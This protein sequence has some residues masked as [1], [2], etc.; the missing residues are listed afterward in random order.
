MPAPLDAGEREFRC[1][2][3]LIAA[4][5]SM[6][7]FEVSRWRLRRTRPGT[8]QTRIPE[9]DHGGPVWRQLSA[10]PTYR[11][12]G[13]VPPS[14]RRSFRRRVNQSAD[15]NGGLRDESSAGPEERLD[16]DQTNGCRANWPAT[17]YS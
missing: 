4:I 10:I 8:D 6:E 2:R 12:I 3:A 14:V 1:S 5:L 7:P 11:A 13:R 17:Q 15:G 16:S 9:V